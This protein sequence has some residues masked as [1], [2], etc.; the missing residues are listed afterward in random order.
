M[1]SRLVLAN[2]S[3]FLSHYHKDDA[4]YMADILRSVVEKKPELC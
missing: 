1:I 2:I 4:H 3:T